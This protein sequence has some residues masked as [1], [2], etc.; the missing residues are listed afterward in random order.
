VVRGSLPTCVSCIKFSRK[1][2]PASKASPSPKAYDLFEGSDI[3]RNRMWVR[4]FPQKV[5]RTRIPK[6]EPSP[7]LLSTK[8]KVLTYMVYSPLLLST[9]WP[10][11][12]QNPFLQ[13]PFSQN[14][15]LGFTE[16]R[17]RPFAVLP[18]H[19]TRVPNFL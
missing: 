11:V 16:Q 17:E 4:K 8:Y 13:N 6:K 9:W 14:Q 18:S 7:V 10:P 12:S 1:T 19:A 15:F 2:F 5:L 3:T